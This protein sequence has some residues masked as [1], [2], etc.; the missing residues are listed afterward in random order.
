MLFPAGPYTCLSISCA[1]ALELGSSPFHRLFPA[2]GVFFPSA[3]SITW[4]L[5]IFEPLLQASLYSSPWEYSIH[6]VGHEIY[7]RE[8]CILMSENSKDRS[9]RISESDKCY[10]DNKIGWCGRKWMCVVAGRYPFIG[11]SREDI[12]EWMMFD[13]QGNIKKEPAM[14]RS[15]SSGEKAL[16]VLPIFKY[17]PPF[18]AS[19]D[20]T[21]ASNLPLSSHLNSSP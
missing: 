1:C 4:F 8:S 20:A 3:L 7:S 11:C 19:S 12:S 15:E 5:Y 16:Q 2:P 17:Y 21:S 9:T 13:F 18:K 6:Q 10:E 14:W